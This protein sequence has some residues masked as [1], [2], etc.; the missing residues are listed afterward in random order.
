VELKGQ[1]TDL[2]KKQTHRSDG[3]SPVDQAFGVCY[4]H[5]RCGM[6]TTLQLR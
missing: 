2:D 6:D 1:N 5:G 4:T 3:R